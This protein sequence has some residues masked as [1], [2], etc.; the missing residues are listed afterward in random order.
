MKKVVLGG[1]MILT[2][3]V[4]AAILMSGTMATGFTHNGIYSY[5]WSLSQYQLTTPF[6]I[7]TIIAIIGFTL[8]IWDLFEKKG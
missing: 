1:I 4:S 3:I 7:F 8:N 2:G 6:Y 5:S